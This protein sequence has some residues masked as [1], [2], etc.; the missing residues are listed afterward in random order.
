MIDKPRV[1]RLGGLDAIESPCD[2]P[3]A[4]T[5]VCLHGYGADMRDL[6]PPAREIRAGR[7][8]RW[9]FPD[10]PNTLDWGGKAWFPIDIAAFEESQRTGTPRDLSTSEPQ[11]MAESRRR[12]QELLV[13]LGAD[14][15]RLVLMGFSQGSMMAV[16]LALRAPKTKTPAGVV[17]LSG[18]LVDGRTLASLAPRHKGLPFFQ[19]HGSADPILGFRQALELEKALT[20]AGWVGRL[21]RFEAGHGVPPEIIAELGD[22]LETL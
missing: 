13:E 19:S 8:L 1:V 6:V 5:V 4:L 12:L 21:R 10:A 15:G 3:K 11:G 17:I 18:A 14:W 16:D 20:S 7:P 22:W 2:D 9:I